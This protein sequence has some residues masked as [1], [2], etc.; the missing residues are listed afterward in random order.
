MATLPKETVDHLF[1]ILINSLIQSVH[2]LSANT[3]GAG[4]EGYDY[5]QRFAKISSELLSRLSF[6]MSET[7]R[8]NLI[9]LTTRMYGLE[10]FRNTTGYTNA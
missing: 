1:G 9:G 10:A 4:P 7:Q 8:E 6:R 2:H 5:S 3:R